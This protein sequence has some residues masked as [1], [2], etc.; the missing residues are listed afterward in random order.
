MSSVPNHLQAE[1]I[2][3]DLRKFKDVDYKTTI[4]DW[5]GN[6]YQGRLYTDYQTG[7][8]VYELVH[9]NTTIA[10][11]TTLVPGKVICTYFDASYHSSTTR[12]FQSRIV[13]AMGRSAVDTL[14][15]S[16]IYYELSH[17][18]AIRGIVDLTNR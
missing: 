17:P 5:R 3:S 9:W 11:F 14:A 16:R 13:N 2:A 15:Q 10:Q 6:S 1:R 18:T 8:P 4:K 12:A 7:L